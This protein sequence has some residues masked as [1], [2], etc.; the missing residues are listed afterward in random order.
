[1]NSKH[2]KNIHLLHDVIEGLTKIGY[3]AIKGE[4]DYKIIFKNKAGS[5]IE[6]G[7]NQLENSDYIFVRYYA[8]K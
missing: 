3:N 1:M 4:F 5:K 6:V 8:E 7:L 2:Y